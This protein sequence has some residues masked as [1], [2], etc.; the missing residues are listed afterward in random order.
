MSQVWMSNTNT[1]NAIAMS[2]STMGY[3]ANANSNLLLFKVDGNTKFG[4]NTDGDVRANNIFANTFT[5]FSGIGYLPNTTGAVFAG[6]L[7]T[8][9]LTARGNNALILSGATS[10]YPSQL[11]IAPTAHA[12]SRRAAVIFENWAIGQDSNGNGI[13]DFFLYDGNASATRLYIGN[14]GLIGI[15][16]TT[17]TSKLE[18]NGSA[19][20]SK[21]DVR[22]IPLNTQSSLYAL[23]IGDTGKVVSTT[24]NVFVPNA[25]FSSGQAISI[26]NRS[27][28]T[29]NI[30]A[31]SGV[32]FALAG[33]SNNA[34]KL[35]AQNGVAT[36]ICVAANTFVIS[37]AGL[38]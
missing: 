36:I 14:T 23:T 22:D 9:T 18:V 4:V 21:G 24:G 30:I 16:T 8:G 1:Y 34:N 38:A 32:S 25:V 10:Q 35:L 26:F 2:V 31:N 3:G 19:K 12:T 15:G 13:K 6:D 5:T 33:L 7:T 11:Y 17:P 27:A 28:V 29:I 37:G 20:D